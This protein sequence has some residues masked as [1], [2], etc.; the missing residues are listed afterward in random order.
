MNNWDLNNPPRES[1]D[2]NMSFEYLSD[3][4]D[5]TNSNKQTHPN[6]LYVENNRLKSSNV[7]LLHEFSLNDSDSNPSTASTNDNSSMSESSDD[8]SSLTSL[9]SVKSWEEVF[10]S[11][12]NQSTSSNASSSSSTKKIKH[13]NSPASS[14]HTANSLSSTTSKNNEYLRNKFGCFNINKQYNHECSA[15]LMMKGRFSFLSFQEPFSTNT[16]NNKSW[17]AYRVSN[18]ASA[19]FKAFESQHQV[20][21]IDENSWGGKNLE[22]LQCFQEGR[23]MAIPFLISEKQYLGIISIY[24]IT[25]GNEILANGE[26]KS[27]IRSDTSECVDKIYNKWLKKFPTMVI[28]IIGDLQETWNTSN[29]D[30]F[31]TFRKD[32]SSEGILNLFATS[33]FSIVRKDREAEGNHYWT[34]RGQCGSRGIDHILLPNTDT[35]F[36]WNCK[37]LLEEELSKKFYNSDHT[38]LSCSFDRWSINETP[39]PKPKSIFH[40]DKI[41]NIRIKDDFSFDDSR[42]KCETFFEQKELYNKLQKLTDPNSKLTTD[43]LK[44]ISKKLNSLIR[45]IWDVSVSSGQNGANNNLVKISHKM[46]YKL[47]EISKDTRDI[48][49]LLMYELKL[50]T[51]GDDSN[52]SEAK[53]YNLNKSGC[54]KLYSTLPAP[55]KL[56]LIIKITTRFINRLKNIRSD[57]DFER[58]LRVELNA[59]TCYRAVSQ[60]VQQEG[61]V[62]KNFKHNSK[63]STK[64]VKGKKQTNTNIERKIINLINSKAL[65]EK[66]KDL[67]KC[68][69]SDKALWDTHIEAIKHSRPTQN[70]STDKIYGETI[71]VKGGDVL[72]EANI[73]DL[74]IINQFAEKIDCK[75]VLKRANDSSKALDFIKITAQA[76]NWQS[77]LK[78][79][80]NW[81][82]YINTA[83]DEQLEQ[84]PTFIQSAIKCLKKLKNNLSFK[85][86]SY[87]HEKLNHSC[88]TNNMNA[89]TNSLKPKEQSVPTV[90]DLYYDASIEQYRQCVNIQEQMIATKQHHDQWMQPSKAKKSCF[91]AELIKDGPLGIRGIKNFPEKIF[92]RED[93]KDVIHNSEQLD[94]ETINRIIQAHGPHTAEEFKPPKSPNPL[95]NYPFFFINGEGDLPNT[96]IEDDFWKAIK[97]IPSKARHEDFQLAIFGRTNKIWAEAILKLA[98]LILVMRLIPQNI[99]ILSRI[100]IPKPDRPNE[101]RPLSVCDDLFCFVNS[102]FTKHAS[103]ATELAKTLHDGVTAYRP[104]RGC[105]SLVAVELAAREDCIESG[106]MC[107]LIMED[108]EKFFDRLTAENILNAMIKA[109]FPSQGYVEFKGSSMSHKTVIIKTNKGEITTSFEC[110]LEQGNPDS[111]RAANLV[112]M[113]IHNMWR[114]SSNKNTNYVFNTSDPN[115][116]NVEVGETGFSDDNEVLVWDVDIDELIKIIQDKINMTGDLSIVTK[117]GR[118]GKKCAILLFNVLAKDVK[119]LKRF[120]SVAWSFNDDKPMEEEIEVIIYMQA[121]EAKKMDEN[122]KTSVQITFDKDGSMI[123]N[124]IE[125]FTNIKHLGL[126]MRTDGDTTMSA[127]KV[128]GNIKSKIALL[129]VKNLQDNPQRHSCNMLLNTLHSYATVENNIDLLD[130]KDCDKLLVQNLRR[131]KGL[132]SSD[133][134]LPFFIKEKNHGFGFKS[135]VDAYLTSIARELNIALNGNALYT[136]STRARL[137]AFTNNK[138]GL[139]SSISLNHIKDACVKLADFGI[140]IRDSQDGLL[141]YLIEEARLWKKKFPVGTDGHSNK[142]TNF[143]GEG[144][145]ELRAFMMGSPY[146][147]LITK[148]IKHKHSNTTKKFLDSLSCRKNKSLLKYID[149][150]WKKSLQQKEHDSLQMFHFYE[151][152]YNS[153]NIQP[154]EQSNWTYHNGEMTNREC[155]ESWN[156]QKIWLGKA[157]AFTT[158]NLS[159]DNSKYEKNFTTPKKYQQVFTKISNSNSPLIIS[160]DGGLISINDITYATAAISWCLLKIQ[161]CETISDGKWE[162]RDTIPILQRFCILPQMIGTSKVDISHAELLA[163]CMQEECLPPNIPRI[164][165]M[166]SKSVRTKILECRDSEPAS[167]RQLLR[168]MYDGLGKT[169]MSR[170]KLSIN[171][172]KDVF[173]DIANNNQSTDDQK[174]AMAA[175]IIN[176][177]PNYIVKK[178]VKRTASFVDHIQQWHMNTTSTNWKKEYS[179][180]HLLRCILKVDSHQLNTEGNNIKTQKPRYKSL[181]PNLALLSTNHW[182]DRTASIAIKLCQNQPN[183]FKIPNNILLPPNDTRFN[184][185]YD[186]KTIEKQQSTYLLDKLEQERISRMKTKEFQGVLYRIANEIIQIPRDIGRRSSYRRFILNLSKTHTRACYKSKQYLALNILNRENIDPKKA[187]DRFFDLLLTKRLLKDNEEILCCPLC[188][189]QK[190]SLDQNPKGNRRHFMLFC[191]HPRLKTFRKDM[192]DFIE[193]I[194]LKLFNQVEELGGKGTGENFFSKI[195]NTL[196]D[197]NLQKIGKQASRTTIISENEHFISIEKNDTNYVSINDWREMYNIEENTPLNKT[198]KPILQSILGFNTAVPDDALQECSMGLVDFI[199]LGLIPIKLQETIKLFIRNLTSKIQNRAEREKLFNTIYQTWTRIKSVVKGKNIILHRIIG[200]IITERED[201]LRR[202]FKIP[203]TKECKKIVEQLKEDLTNKTKE[204]EALVKI[205]KGPSCTNNN[206]MTNNSSGKIRTPNQIKLTHSQCARCINLN[207]AIN[208]CSIILNSIKFKADLSNATKVANLCLFNSDSKDFLAKF[209]QILLDINGEIHPWLTASNILPQKGR[210]IKINARKPATMAAEIISRAMLGNSKEKCKSNPCKFCAAK[211][212][213]VNNQTKMEQNITSPNSNHPNCDSSKT[214][215]TITC[216]ICLLMAGIE[217]YN[218]NHLCKQVQNPMS[219]THETNEEPKETEILTKTK[220]TGSTAKTI[221]SPL[222]KANILFQNKM[223][224]KTPPKPK[225]RKNIAKDKMINLPPTTS[226]NTL[227]HKVEKQAI[228]QKSS[229]SSP[230]PSTKRKNRNINDHSQKEVAMNMR[231]KYSPKRQK[232]CI[233]NK[234]PCQTVTRKLRIQGNITRSAVINHLVSKLE[235][236]CNPTTYIANANIIN[237]TISW[238]I[239]NLTD[240]PSSVNFASNAAKHR[241]KGIYIFPSY[242]GTFHDGHWVVFCVEKMNNSS[243]KSLTNG[244]IIDPLITNHQEEKSLNIQMLESKTFFNTTIKWNICEN[245]IQLQEN[246][247][248]PRALLTCFII[249]VGI[250]LHRSIRDTIRE[251]TILPIAAK[252]H[253]SHLAREFAHQLSLDIDEEKLKTNTLSPKFAGTQKP[254]STDQGKDKLPKLSV[255]EKSQKNFR[256]IRKKKGKRKQESDVSE[257]SNQKKR[258]GQEQIAKDN[259]SKNIIASTPN[260]SNLVTKQDVRLCKSSPHTSANKQRSILQDG[261]NDNNR[262]NIHQTKQEDRSNDKPT[263][264][265]N[266]KLNATIRHKPPNTPCK[267]KIH[268]V[269][270]I[271]QVISSNAKTTKNNTPNERNTSTSNIKSLQPGTWLNDETINS[272]MNILNDHESMTYNS[273]SDY[274]PSYF[275]SSFFFTALGTQDSYNYNRVKRWSRRIRTC[276][277]IFQLKNLVFPINISNTHWT[278]AN[279]NFINLEIEYLDSMG[280]RGTIYTNTLLKFIEDEHM[281]K[282]G[283]ILPNKEEWK[284]ISRGTSTPQQPNTFDCGV[285]VCIY[286]DAFSRNFHP[287]E[288]SCIHHDP[289]NAL[290]SMIANNTLGTSQLSTK[291]TNENI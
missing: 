147:N 218:H 200:E 160:T 272:F 19:N 29:L 1:L 92:T 142:N 64:E 67:S 260:S 68:I 108:I 35:L 248:G 59:N 91:Y 207:T 216:P 72:D 62:A 164:V 138:Y 226:S 104:G 192:S 54:T 228:L 125:D 15:E 183:L 44:P 116:G 283:E 53:R 155:T 38:L 130:L 146:H 250:K 80:R 198:N 251:A 196:I 254:T 235:T 193:K 178:L 274:K 9:S 120:L 148:F 167:D 137:R 66:I 5:S 268:A 259:A 128:I 269:V 100:P 111:P 82:G 163:F 234:T 26:S 47:E 76:T 224:D 201:N 197:K 291:K 211:M 213:M 256:S 135:F 131:R 277:N 77:T 129:N 73:E 141:N 168:S 52:N 50:V 6:T 65:K 48:I 173:S 279:I 230:N 209:L 188:S 136:K 243:N 34:R 103:R 204:G 113:N 171:L 87:K 152:T 238:G 133:S 78:K 107:A 33:H 203:K 227:Q 240:I 45:E 118:K 229:E 253:T 172:W 249:I 189:L 205:C 245:C 18:L 39:S 7:N 244:W 270:D 202:K 154:S 265:F 187:S 126:T 139:G 157:K 191:C 96:F 165:V 140:Y 42:F 93:V 55:S 110:G 246:E 74:E 264:F 242:L 121:K 90:H 81:A 267:E 170:A 17:A 98:K 181:T 20:I 290:S 289:R 124:E 159:T 106:K 49:D 153:N 40:F 37:G 212:D 185:V 221:T 239:K 281:D 186:S 151:W 180:S 71:S 4:E 166:D 75:H 112:I 89:L 13:N 237:Y 94:E 275:F 169:L 280:D 143:L 162:K 46:T 219:N 282:L 84:M 156:I 263:Q 14:D 194:A 61:C 284:T 25:S 63:I 60:N 199:Y 158:I 114:K 177:T 132:S 247:C 184:I 99:N 233:E 2:S 32:I 278:L 175:A 30:N 88:E 117:L 220:L 144:N 51:D 208:R 119:K 176:K 69:S 8:N 85:Q 83:D 195:N 271:E 3:N 12:D 10:L 223:L 79:C 16:S 36:T 182:A 149:S 109:G 28:S 127:S 95:F 222:I 105:H 210:G 266:S 115:D 11:D 215:A 232:S 56:R 217:S 43:H 57:I 134:S 190:P 102:V 150:T 24:A 22:E 252:N 27:K 288:I 23:V 101:Y 273:Q 145:P 231:E 214:C 236:I 41:Y 174:V 206:D 86:R 179:D 287:T 262:F 58:R 97:K 225:Q 285:Y 286:A 122:L 70:V 276:T 255:R 123:I 241:N 21:V 258:K 257:T 161:P 261:S 31:G